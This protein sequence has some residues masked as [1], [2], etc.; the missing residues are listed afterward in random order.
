MGGSSSTN[1]SQG[2]LRGIV[3]FARAAAEYLEE[4]ALQGAVAEHIGERVDC[5]V[6]EEQR[7]RVAL[8]LEHEIGRQVALRHQQRREYVEG[9]EEGNEQEVGDHDAQQNRAQVQRLSPAPAN[10]RC[11]GFWRRR[12]LLLDL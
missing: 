1:I 12:L 11:Y 4:V 7:P 6:Q 3:Q 5:V 8:R 2:N 9:Q 10:R